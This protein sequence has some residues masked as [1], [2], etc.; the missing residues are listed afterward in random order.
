MRAPAGVE[1]I[2]HSDLLP[3]FGAFAPGHGL[4]S[5]D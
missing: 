5:E 4:A 3:E 1:H 2:P